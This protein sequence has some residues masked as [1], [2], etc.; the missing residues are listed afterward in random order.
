MFVHKRAKVPLLLIALVLCP[1]HLAYYVSSLSLRLSA[2]QYTKWTVESESTQNT[3]TD[4]HI[5]VDISID[6][7]IY[8]CA[9]K[10]KVVDS[11]KHYR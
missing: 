9:K 1:F 2:K 4:M 8:K 3:A 6:L 5:Y 11:L 7:H 10:S